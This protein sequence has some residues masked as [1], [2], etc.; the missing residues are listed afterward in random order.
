MTD[1]E[2]EIL[3]G[4]SEG[5]GKLPVDPI[6]GF[7]YLPDKPSPEYSG[8]LWG[9]ADTGENGPSGRLDMQ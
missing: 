6:T 3:L 8:P 4:C 1:E 5:L 2:K 7:S 9:P